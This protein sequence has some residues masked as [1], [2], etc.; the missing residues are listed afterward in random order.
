M[1]KTSAKKATWLFLRNTY[2]SMLIH[3]CVSHTLYLFTNNMFSAINTKRERDYDTLKCRHGYL[4]NQL[5]VFT[6]ECINIVD[7]VQN[8]HVPEPPLKVVLFV[9]KLRNLV[10]PAATRSVHFKVVSIQFV[11][12]RKLCIPSA[13]TT[14]PYKALQSRERREHLLRTQLVAMSSFFF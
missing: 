10:T 1:Y 12:V 2:P 5:L 9:A 7:F 6:N 11:T 8:H 3:G 4:F 13:M 14:I